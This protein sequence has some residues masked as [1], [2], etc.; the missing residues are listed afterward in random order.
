MTPR[1]LDAITEWL[2]YI[3]VVL[4]GYEALVGLMWLGMWLR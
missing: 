2:L 4:G 1:A 3:A